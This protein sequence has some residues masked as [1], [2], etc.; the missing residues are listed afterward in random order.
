MNFNAH[1]EDLFAR[2]YS[3]VSFYLNGG[4]PGLCRTRFKILLEAVHHLHRYFRTL[5]PL[6]PVQTT[7]YYIPIG[8]LR[9]GITGF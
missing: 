8:P 7:T 4:S 5:V 9:N 3:L 2:P 1:K 6:Y